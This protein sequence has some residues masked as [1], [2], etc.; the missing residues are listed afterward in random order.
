M[1]IEI[2]LTAP[3]G[4]GYS[5]RDLG[6]LLHKHPDH[7]HVRDLPQ[8]KGRMFFSSAAAEEATAV[9]HLEI[10]PVGLVRGKGEGSGMLD[11]YVNDRPYVVNSLMSVALGRV[12]GQTLAGKSKERSD[13]ASRALPL[14]LRLTPLAVSGGAEIVRRLFSPLGY[15]IAI[16]TLDNSGR[17]EILDVSLSAEVRLSDLLTHVQVLIPVMDNATHYFVGPD[18]IEKLLAK[19]VGWLETH[20]EKELI[21]WRALRRRSELAR[22]ALD[23]L[24]EGV[25]EPLVHDAPQQETSAQDG[26]ALLERPTRLHDLRLNAVRDV[27]VEAGARSV[28]D[29]G[30][31][32]GRLLRLMMRERQIDKITGVDPSVRTLEAAARRLNL[33]EAGAALRERV[34]LMLGSL[35]YADRRWGGYDA[36]ALVEVIEHVDPPCLSALELSLFDVARPKLVI[37]TTPNRDYN[38]LF[39]RM[40]AGELRHGDHRFEWSRAEFADWA[41]GVAER[42]GYTPEIRP[43]G[44][45][46]ET[47][48]APSQMALFRRA[49]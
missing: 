45:E 41:Q 24:A 31:G 7:L 8:G 36:A 23:R 4:C 18:E 32:E 43:L 15:E 17:L 28:L 46:D 38:V 13:L 19:G 44:P 5:A 2:T 35:T 30:C 1:Q 42:N 26:E 10:D 29:L 20:P 21:V 49:A 37:V 25:V 22:P 9:L 6:F 3:S 34:Q 11:Q 16:G 27:V 48:G 47:V 12:L 14:R 33:D 39:D 40:A